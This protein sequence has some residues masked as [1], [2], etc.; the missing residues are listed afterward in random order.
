MRHVVRLVVDLG[1]CQSVSCG[2][3]ADVLHLQRC[4]TRFLASACQYC[5]VP[6]GRES[7]AKPPRCSHPCPVPRL[8]R[9]AAA[10]PPHGCHFGPCPPCP[11][12][13]ATTLACGH[14]CGQQVCH[15]PP[16]PVVPQYAAPPPPVAP[17]GPAPGGASSK[18]RAAQQQ[19]VPPAQAAA[20]EARRLLE[21]LPRTPGGHITLCPACAVPVPV[22]CIGGHTTVS[23]P[24]SS[25]APFACEQRCG[26]PLACGN[27][28]CQAGC[29]DPEAQP[30]RQCSLPCQVARGTCQHPCP[31]PCHPPSQ[32]CPACEQPITRPC[33]CGKTTLSEQGLLC[34]GPEEAS[35]L[36]AS[37]LVLHPSCQHGSYHHGNHRN[38]PP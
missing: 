15:D 1:L 5:S 17:V 7:T 27:H 26:R 22:S 25:A 16:P 20:A 14:T 37:S 3:A 11:F 31:L 29:H 19:Q 32:A 8:C 12:G 6:C 38:L 23:L 30:C 4:P 34:S 13:C 10:L 9:H 35:K 2:H 24:C 33:H 28:S 36:L 18:Q 21:R